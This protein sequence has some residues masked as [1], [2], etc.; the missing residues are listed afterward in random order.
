MLSHTHICLD[1]LAEFLPG[2]DGGA[3]FWQPVEGVLLRD[4][5]WGRRS[6]WIWNL[7]CQ[8]SNCF[9][10]C[11]VIS[12]EFIFVLALRLTDDEIEKARTLIRDAKATA[13]KLVHEMS[14]DLDVEMNEDAE[15]LQ[16]SSL[17]HPVLLKSANDKLGWNAEPLESHLKFSN[18]ESGPALMSP[19]TERVS[20]IGLWQ[21]YWQLEP[22]EAAANHEGR[23]GLFFGI[24]V[25]LVIG[26]SLWFL[27][28]IDARVKG[29]FCFGD[30]CRS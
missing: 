29:L 24:F 17:F 19:V 30:V 10:E 4:G 14:K 27:Q 15:N 12:C 13:T 2:N 28:V 8:G 26:S 21:G 3:D 11:Q 25:L 23:V 16:M 7:L 9:G 22:R 18:L 1:S 5:F 20:L 6:C